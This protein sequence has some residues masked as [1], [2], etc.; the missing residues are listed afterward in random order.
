MFHP[1]S[2]SG[3]HIREAGSDAV[4]EIAFTFAN[5]EAYVR[6]LLERGID[7]DVLGP[8]LA[9]FFG[10]HNH[11]LEEIAKFRAARRVWARIMKDDFGAK[12]PKSQSLRFHV[13]TCGSTLTSQQPFNNAMRVAWQAMAAVL[14]GAQSLH[15]NSYDEALAL[16]SEE[17]AQLALRTQ[18]VL[19]HETGVTAAV[20][21]V[22]GAWAIE[23]LTDELER[24]VTQTLARLRAAG[25]ML[26]L[27]EEELP[28]REI[29]ESAYRYQREIED[30]RRRI[31]GVNALRLDEEPRGA[32]RLKVSPRL[33]AE[34]VRRLRTFRKKRDGKAAAAAVARLG[35]AARTSENLFPRILA[36]VEAR[37]TIGEIFGA[38]R[39]A[40]GEFR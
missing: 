12:D 40:L 11:F 36:A 37:A 1:I 22:G 13:Q 8:K 31:V 6:A 10:C 16:P 35:A 24:R 34:Q 28:Q 26:K 33:E 18:Q 21:P 2:I 38:L 4:Q 20:D 7:V 25:G 3:Y 9:F 32:P 17:S 14:G 30:G 5:A 29:Q 15:T 19:A 23:A 39:G 27:I